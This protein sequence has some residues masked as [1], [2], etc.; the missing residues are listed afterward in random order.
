MYSIL[1]VYTIQSYTIRYNLQDTYNSTM[2][3]VLHFSSLYFSI[4]CHLKRNAE[5]QSGSSV[6][7]INFV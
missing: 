4:L 1:Y 6:L 2:K 3:T 7:S 5:N